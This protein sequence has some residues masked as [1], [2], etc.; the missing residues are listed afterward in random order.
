MTSQQ[1][2]ADSGAAGGHPMK[3]NTTDYHLISI[4][5]E[6]AAC[7]LVNVM[8]GSITKEL[9][10]FVLIMIITLLFVTFKT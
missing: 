3:K 9:R 1:M 10:S 6:T 7:C 8:Y 5:Y 2:A 4:R